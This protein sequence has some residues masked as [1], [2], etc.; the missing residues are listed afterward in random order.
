[1]AV[2]RLH[3]DNSSADRAR[4]AFRAVRETPRFER[5]LVRMATLAHRETPA[6]ST[7]ER[8]AQAEPALNTRT[9]RLLSAGV[10]GNPPHPVE[11]IA[12][13]VERFGHEACIRASVFSTLEAFCAAA[14]L[15][16]VLKPRAFL[17]HALASAVVT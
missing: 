15:G 1:M 6:R 10:P 13:A 14:F 17:R 4:Q 3:V 11:S 5:L 12:E 9:L 8:V 2:S 7:Y 16:P